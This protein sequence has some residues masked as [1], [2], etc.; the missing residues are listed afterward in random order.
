MSMV[1]M[2]IRLSRI[3]RPSTGTMSSAAEECF[4][5]IANEA[6]PRFD[7]VPDEDANL[8]LASSSA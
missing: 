5:Q 8:L 1:E 2:P 3:R 7:S 6:F 4:D